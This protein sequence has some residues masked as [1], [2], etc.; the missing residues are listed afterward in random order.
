MRCDHAPLVVGDLDEL[1]AIVADI[2]P[3]GKGIPILIRQ[4][5]KLGGRLLG[6]NLDP[7]FSNAL[8]GLIVVDLSQ[9]SPSILERYM[10]KKE[11]A[12]FLR[13]HNAPHAS[14]GTAS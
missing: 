4:Y 13:Y 11:A 8:D 5:L 1:S 2:E 10:G 7:A 14:A 9:T 12:G 3:D 6:F